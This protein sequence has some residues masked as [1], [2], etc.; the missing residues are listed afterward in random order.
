M[1]DSVKFPKQ[2]L[3]DLEATAPQTFDNFITGKNRPLVE[4]MQSLHPFEQGYS[5]SIYCW[6]EEGCGKSHLLRA[7]CTHWQTVKPF[8][9]NGEQLLGQALFDT[10]DGPTVLVFDNVH[11]FIGNQEREEELLYLLRKCYE[12]DVPLL[13]SADKPPQSLNCVLEDLA[14]RLASFYV[15]HIHPLDEHRAMEFIADQAQKLGLAFND[16]VKERIRH[17]FL[18]GDMKFLTQLLRRLALTEK[19]DR[20]S[21]QELDREW[22]LLRH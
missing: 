7:Y 5:H 4:L 18:S 20:L 1:I 10:N 13:L 2:L 17:H 3:L 14:T 22:Q 12:E 9:F 11:A 8:Y 15:F 19:Q 16:Q 21:L 6:A